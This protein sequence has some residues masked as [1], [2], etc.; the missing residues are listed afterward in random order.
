[1]CSLFSSQ[2]T[3]DS[4]TIDT[5]HTEPMQQQAWTL[6]P[7]PTFIYKAQP[8]TTS[9]SLFS[10]S[11]LI[12]ISAVWLHSSLPALLVKLFM[13]LTFDGTMQANSLS[14][15]VTSVLHVQTTLRGGL[16]KTYIIFN[17]HKHNHT[18][19]WH[20]VDWLRLT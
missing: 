11:F 10:P 9:H 19:R 12:C 16:V 7:A 14:T 3:Q 13:I 1:M 2:V 4:R 18:P 8:P 20:P 6:K 15:K 17:L 5:R